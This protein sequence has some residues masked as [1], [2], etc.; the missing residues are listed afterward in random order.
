M[1]PGTLGGR[2]TTVEGLLEQV[3]FELDTRIP[4]TQG[5]A[6]SDSRRQTFA[7]FLA[8]LRQV[9]FVSFAVLW[10]DA[11]ASR[12]CISAL[13]FLSPPYPSPLTLQVIELEFPF[14]LIL[15]DPLGN[16]YL[17]NIYAP[18]SD[19]NMLV[20]HFERTDDQNEMFGLND[21]NTENYSAEEVTNE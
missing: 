14:T 1:T 9:R 20:E 11:A 3:F 5:D 6:V 2:F 13:I 8:K 10:T 12:Q 21:L 18:D 16:S 7:A 4:F 17:Q 15:E 19:P